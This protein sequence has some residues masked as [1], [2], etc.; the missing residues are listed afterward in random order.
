VYGE[1]EVPMYAS[2]RQAIGH[3]C[4]PAA[5]LLKRGNSTNISEIHTSTSPSIVPMKKQ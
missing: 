5:L 2:T 4:A 1:G 3:S